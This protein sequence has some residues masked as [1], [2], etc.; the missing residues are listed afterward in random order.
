MDSVERD[1]DKQRRPDFGDGVE[2]VSTMSFD[3]PESAAEGSA[4]HISV[5]V[6]VMNEQE[7]LGPLYSRLSAVL[8]KSD[9][10]YELIFVDDGSTDGS[11]EVLQ[12]FYEADPRVRVIRF[13]CNFGQTA[14]FS[15]GFA[16]ASGEVIVTLDA[17]LQNDPADIPLLL[18]QVRQ[19]Y[20]LVSG[21]RLKR[22][23]S[24]VSRRL[25][26]YVANW[27]IGRVLGVRLHD[28]GC[29]LKAYRRG[30]VKKIRLYGEL[31]RFI[32][33]LA[34]M[35]GARITEVPVAHHPRVYGRS[36]YGISRTFRVLLDVLAVKFML[37]G[38]TSPLRS[39]GLPGLGC[40]LLGTALTLYSTGTGAASMAL[41]AP[42]VMLLAIGAQFLLL[43]LLGG[44][45]LNMHRKAREQTSYIV[46]ERLQHGETT[47]GEV[48]EA[49]VDAVPSGGHGATS[50]RERVAAVRSLAEGSLQ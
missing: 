2:A 39:L 3:G 33:A 20:D 12:R 31:H 26:S 23:D 11:F 49:E 50:G 18:D 35:A 30:L 24:L 8:G 16:E 4:L 7:S 9:A 32:P 47:R 21:W 43:G 27:L 42:G 1:H 46:K 13:S 15:A 29:S 34:A 38:P 48:F 10:N 45:V 17:D 14:A 37:A 25:P 40:L 6:P 19:G 28:Y 36:K 41:I 5:V 22:Q 44:W